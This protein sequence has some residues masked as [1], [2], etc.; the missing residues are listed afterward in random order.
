LRGLLLRLEHDALSL[1]GL[2]GQLLLGELTG[3]GLLGKLGRLHLFVLFVRD[4]L[5]LQLRD[6]L[7]LVGVD[8]GGCSDRDGVGANG[9]NAVVMNEG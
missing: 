3:L 6:L 7:G 2:L 8:G 4:D 1:H 5:L 9:T